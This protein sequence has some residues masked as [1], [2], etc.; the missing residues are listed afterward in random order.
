MRG[1][2]PRRLAGGQGARLYQDNVPW[3]PPGARPLG[4]H[5][6]NVPWKPPG[7]RP[8][9][10]HQDNVPWKPPGARS[11]GFHQDNGYLDFVVTGEM[12]KHRRNS[13]SV[14][15]VIELRN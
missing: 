3:K 9:G 1:S 10:F 7:A 5:Q 2:R 6:D 13:S 4:F 15:I 12:A 8:L 11:L 14:R